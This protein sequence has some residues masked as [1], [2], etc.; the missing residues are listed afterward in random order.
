MALM[1]LF[2]GMPAWEHASGQSVSSLS[3]QVSN[4][5]AW[6]QA[7]YLNMPFVQDAIRRWSVK[8]GEPVSRVM[9]GRH[10]ETMKFPG[11]TCVQFAFTGPSVGGIPVYC[12]RLESDPWG[13]KFSLIEEYSNVE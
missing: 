10:A 9:E 13:P 12:Y 7:D 1:I 3:Q 2:A 8:G 11:K 6:K 4:Y 5:L